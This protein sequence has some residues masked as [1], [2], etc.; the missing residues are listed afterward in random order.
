MN[1][2]RCKSILSKQTYKGVEVDRCSRCKGMWLDYHELDELEDTVMD[3]D[4]EKGMVMFRSFQGD[5][6]CPVCDSGM[7]MFNYRAFELELDYCPSEHGFW[8]DAGEEKRVLEIMEQR[9]KDLKRAANAEGEWAGMM[10]RLK[11]KGFADKMKGMFR[12]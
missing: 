6:H 10:K 11:S 4:D 7:Q 1:C 9:P 5:L 12:R 8:L 2:P 3:D